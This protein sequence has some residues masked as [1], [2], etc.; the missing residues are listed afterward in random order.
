MRIVSLLPSATEMVCALGLEEQLVGIS[1]ECDFPRTIVGLPAVTKTHIDHHATSPNIDEQ[2][3]EELGSQQALY[4]LHDDLLATLKP[5][6]IVTQSL[7][8]VCAVAE[9]DV[10]AVAGMLNTQPTVFNMQPMTLT[11]V[12]ET[13]IAL[14]EA[15]NSQSAARKLRVD[16]ECRI[17]AVRARSATLKLS[18]RPRVAFLEW[19]DPPFNAGH[20]NPELV[21]IAGAEPVLGI[22]GEPSTT[23]SWSQVED[24]DP[25][26]IVIGCCG[27][28]LQRTVVDVQMLANNPAWSRIPCVRN[29]RVFIVDG[30]A[31]FNRPGPRLVDSLEL[32]ANTLHPSLHPLPSTVPPAL[33]FAEIAI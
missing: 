18:E 32:M 1:H 9:A 3:R 13:V 24:C 22:A 25:D 5:D 20:W 23:V 30:N 26:I 19:L 10:T 12:L 6:L 17:E 21:E 27:F 7:C 31:Y 16:L 2:V 14:G 15:A 4:S 28:D 33:S 11:D 29:G 8:D